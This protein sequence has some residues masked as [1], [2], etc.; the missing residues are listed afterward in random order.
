MMVAVPL[1]ANKTNKPSTLTYNQHKEGRT[2]IK[3]R[4]YVENALLG[5]QP[6]GTE[7]VRAQTAYLT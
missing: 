6:T 5:T 4:K 3:D 2:H 1:M 7:G